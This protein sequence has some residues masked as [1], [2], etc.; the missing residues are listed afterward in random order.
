MCYLVDLQKAFYE[1]ISENILDGIVGG[2]VLP[3]LADVQR[4]AFRDA[5]RPPLLSRH[6]SSRPGHVAVLDRKRTVVSDAEYTTRQDTCDSQIRIG[7]S[8]DGFDLKIPRARCQ[9]FGEPNR[10]LAVV[11]PPTDP[12]AS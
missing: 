10:C 12:R 1:L 9:R 5:Q 6:F 3:R 7:R 8:V 11:D 4:K 2:Q